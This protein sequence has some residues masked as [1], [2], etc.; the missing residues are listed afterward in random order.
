MEI[1]LEKL[2]KG[3]STKIN[4]KDFLSTEDYVKNFIDVTNKLTNT[5][6]IEAITPR[7]LTTDG[8]NTDLTY[9]RVLIQAILPNKV[10]KYNEIIALTY[11]LD[12]RKPWYKVYRAFYD[13]TTN[14]T[15]VFNQDWI[16]VNELKPLEPIEIDIDTLLSWTN[17]FSVKLNECK[18]NL[19][20][21]KVEE[22]CFRLGE[23][24]EKC[25]FDYYNHEINGKVKW[26][27]ANIIKVYNSIYIDQNSEYYVGDKDS[28]VLNTYCAFADIV[29]KDQKDIG[30]RFEKTILINRL[31]KIK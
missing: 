26:S 15:L 23:W 20:S 17:N 4:E 30:N 27:P 16:L 8:N 11:A 28:T 19:L 14:Q 25:Q 2:L 24:I 1:T 21:T 13:N 29:A 12:V 10:D 6:R 18:A 5:Y 9:N 3:K 31:L 22:R 7:Q